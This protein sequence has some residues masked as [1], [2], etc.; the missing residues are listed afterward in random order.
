MML[1]NINFHQ[2]GLII[3]I[4]NHKILKISNQKDMVS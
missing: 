2:M 1:I 4:I 3:I